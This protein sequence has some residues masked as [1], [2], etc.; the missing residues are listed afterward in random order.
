MDTQQSGRVSLVDVTHWIATLAGPRAGATFTAAAELAFKQ[1][2]DGR[3]QEAFLHE[4]NFRAMCG[5]FAVFAAALDSFD[6]LLGSRSIGKVELATD[7]NPEQ[8]TKDPTEAEIVESKAPNKTNVI[9]AEAKANDAGTD[10][11][12]GTDET[13]EHEN[14]T[15][16]EHDANDIESPTSMHPDVSAVDVDP[17]ENAASKIQAHI[18]G[19]QAR[20]L[21]AGQTAA[22]R[23]HISKQKWMDGLSLLE[24]HPLPSLSACSRDES[25]AA[26]AFSKMSA[27]GASDVSV[28]GF[29]LWVKTQEIETES[30]IGSLLLLSV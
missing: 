16:A 11:E 19:H 9:N 17:K 26:T 1:F 12:G 7:A 22:K 30:P 27:D 3:D 24:A 28:E 29:L 13:K 5:Y 15:S 21:A 4:N 6:V 2:V 8:T 23:N 20:E 25:M 18:R 10:G 14:L